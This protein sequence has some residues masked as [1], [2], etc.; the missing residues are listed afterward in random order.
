MHELCQYFSFAVS[1]ISLYSILHTHNQNMFFGIQC[2]ISYI[3]FLLPG[4][5]MFSYM[6]PP[7]YLRG[8]LMLPYTV[9]DVRLYFYPIYSMR[10]T[11]STFVYVFSFLVIPV[12]CISSFRHPASNIIPHASTHEEV[13]S[14]PMVL[15]NAEFPC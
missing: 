3:Q 13:F 14:I 6:P 7:G 10:L 5:Y 4:V 2:I 15:H 11:V 8:F 9:Y 12:L 1:Y